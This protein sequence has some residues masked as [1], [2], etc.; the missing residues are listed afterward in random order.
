[1][2]N[3]HSILKYN[4]FKINKISKNDYHGGSLRTV[5]IKK[6]SN[7]ENTHDKNEHFLLH[8]PE[9]LISTSDGKGILLIIFK[10]ESIIFDFLEIF[11]SKNF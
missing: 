4:N 8:I 11:G 9:L 6:S 5:A 2:K 1:M 3:I 7:F 10:L